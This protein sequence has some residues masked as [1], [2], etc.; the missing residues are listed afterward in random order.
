[1][2]L[3]NNTG[4]WL[5]QTEEIAAQFLPAGSVI[6]LRKNKNGEEDKIVVPDGNEPMD[7]PL[8]VLVNGGTASASEILVGALRDNDRALV[9]GETTVGTGT[10]LKEYT[11]KD[12]S[13]ILLGVAEWLT[14]DGDFI[15]ETGIVPDIK[16]PLE[17]RAEPL[18]PDE[19]RSLSKEEILERDAQLRRA[20]EEL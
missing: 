14:P 18:T 11:L 10:T 5:K 2:D 20:F 19:T 15:R 8:V 12:G 13:A 1:L 16:V 7:A 6:Y 17:A 3:R 4:G 9:I